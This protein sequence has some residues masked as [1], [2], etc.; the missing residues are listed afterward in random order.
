MKM[1]F[2]L[3]NPECMPLRA[4][5]WDAGADL[6]STISCSIPPGDMR[7]VDTG[8]A[9]KIPVGYVGLVFSRSSMGKASVTLANSVGVIDES[10]RGNI[11]VMIKNHSKDM[12]YE[13]AAGDRVCQLVVMPVVFPDILVYTGNA[14]DWNDTTRGEAGFGSSGKN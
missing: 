9:L 4:H 10:Y 13:I 5:K 7:M 14:E 3:D 2:K 6:R 1:M 11:K 12:Y 8:V